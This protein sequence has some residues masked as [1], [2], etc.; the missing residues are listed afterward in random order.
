M[1]ESSRACPTP[2]IRPP[3]R[4]GDSKN[5]HNLS[6]KLPKYEDVWKPSD[7]RITVTAG[8]AR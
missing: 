4:V 7:A 5:H 1:A 2:I 3:A 6:V 8:Q